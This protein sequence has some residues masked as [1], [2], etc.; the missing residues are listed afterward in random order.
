MQSLPRFLHQR[1]D[2]RVAE[3]NRGPKIEGRRGIQ[4]DWSQGNSAFGRRG[5]GHQKSSDRRFNR[6]P[7]RHWGLHPLGVQ[8]QL[9]LAL[10]LADRFRYDHCETYPLQYCI[11]AV[12]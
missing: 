8:A 2:Q 7:P 1:S 10:Q 3:E 12:C 4:G 9:V 6:H 11:L 5:Q